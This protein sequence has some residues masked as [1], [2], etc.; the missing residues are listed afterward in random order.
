MTVIFI[1]QIVFWFSIF[2][3]IF[4][5][6][7]NFPLLADFEPETVSK[8]DTFSFRIKKK[9][10]NFQKKFKESFNRWQEKKSSQNKTLDFET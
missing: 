3:I 7:R 6:L 10:N 1:C 9:Y 4:L 2:G 5:F 8:E